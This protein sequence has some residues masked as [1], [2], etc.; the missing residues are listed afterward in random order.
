MATLIKNDLETIRRHDRQNFLRR[1]A[2]F[3]FLLYVV[4]YA[5]YAM[6]DSKALSIYTFTNLINN[7]S[8]LALAAAGQTLVVLTRGFDLSI[9]GTVSITNVIMAVMPL[10]GPFGALGSLAICIA[11]GGIIGSISGYLVAYR[12]LQ[13]VA[14]TL[15][16][17]IV[18]QG[19]ALLILNA[20][21]GAVAEW[22]SYELTATWLNV[23][24]VAIILP[25]IVGGL[26]SLLR[27][28]DL[29]TAIYAVGADQTS[30]ELSGIPVKRTRL[31]AYVLAGGLYGMAGF[32]LSAQTAT[33]DPNAGM[34]FLLLAFAAVALGGTSLNG[35]KGGLIGS[36]IGAAALMLMQKVLFSGGVSSF[37]I[38]LFQGILLIVAIVLG[39]LLN[40]GNSKG[41]KR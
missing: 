39:R 27:R 2:S 4:M 41:A 25:V 17:M 24:P 32:M 6:F 34:P 40:R 11:V 19:V 16:V 12:G 8:P 28:T 35:G 31:M 29:G 33:G 38:G 22:V 1:P 7:A 36:L 21:G 37:Y 30:S 5:I 13:A 18:C 15:G 14:A 23:I 20:P 9:V 3:A 10:E 26:W